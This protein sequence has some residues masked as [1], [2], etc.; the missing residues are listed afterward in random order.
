M[1]ACMG[2]PRR[3]HP[4]PLILGL[5]AEAR[6]PALLSAEPLHDRSKVSGAAAGLRL[7]QSRRRVVPPH[8]AL[9]HD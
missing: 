9:P 6:Q 4:P 1:L 8:A 2:G 7:P 3:A 5:S